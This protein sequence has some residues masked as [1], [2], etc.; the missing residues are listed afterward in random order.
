[1]VNVIPAFCSTQKRW[2]AE[3][4]ICGTED[5]SACRRG[6]ATSLGLVRGITMKSEG[7]CSLTALRPIP[8]KCDES[9]KRSNSLTISFR[10]SGRLPSP[11]RPLTLDA[12]VNAR[13]IVNSRSPRNN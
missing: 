13:M 3:T 4:C 10:V 12:A 2:A 11:A 8:P 7:P 5:L 9:R 6:T 1:M